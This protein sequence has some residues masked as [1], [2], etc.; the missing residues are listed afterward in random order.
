MKAL[1]HYC[2]TLVALIKAK[3]DH[4]RALA[5]LVNAAGGKRTAALCEGIV[6]VL[7]VVYPATDACVGV[8][9]K[10][11]VVSFPRKG[12]G[13]EFYKQHIAPQLPALR[14]PTGGQR[15]AVDPVEALIKQCLKLTAAQRR[16]VKAAI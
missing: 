3:Q 1:E 15:N 9:K 7:R 14:K 4:S 12:A 11:P 2:N 8:Y 16:R 6:T 5:A 10:Q 13:Y